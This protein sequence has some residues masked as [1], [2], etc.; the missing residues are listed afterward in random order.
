MHVFLIA[1]YFSQMAKKF[2]EE[3]FAKHIRSLI[4]SNMTHD[5]QY[6]NIT[7]YL[8]SMG[9]THVSVLTED[10]SAVSVTSSIN[11]MSVSEGVLLYSE[12]SAIKY[13]C[14]FE[15]RGL[16]FK[17]LRNEC[18]CKRNLKRNLS[19]HKSLVIKCWRKLRFDKCICTSVIMS[20]SSSFLVFSSQIWL[21]GLLPEHWSHPQQPAVRLLWKRR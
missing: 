2:T 9:T 14:W 16:R 21:Q 5:P 1:L 12:K 11:H 13:Y 4:S 6:Y 20:R 10:G 7:P 17:R 3:S 15:S 18:F 19:F 8:D